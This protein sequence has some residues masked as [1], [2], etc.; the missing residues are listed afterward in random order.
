M[1]RLVVI[2]GQL[3]VVRSVDALPW[4]MLDWTQS[5]HESLADQT[6]LTSPAPVSSDNCCPRFSALE[7]KG[8]V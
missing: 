5:T 4:F 6:S 1:R 7:R 2:C 3:F 8:Q